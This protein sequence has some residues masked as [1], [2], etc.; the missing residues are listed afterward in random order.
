MLIAVFQA[1]SKVSNKS[2][3]QRRRVSLGEDGFHRDP[4]PSCSGGWPGKGKN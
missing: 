1:R 3:D 2:T 4:A